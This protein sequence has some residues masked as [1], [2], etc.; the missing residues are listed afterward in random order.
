MGSTS[1][2][3]TATENDTQAGGIFI[4]EDMVTEAGSVQVIGTVGGTPGG[5][6]SVTVFVTYAA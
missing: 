2:Y 5:A 3:M 1:A 6:G 4:A